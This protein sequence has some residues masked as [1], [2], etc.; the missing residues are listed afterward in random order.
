[1]S[2]SPP[3]SALQEL[4]AGGF[5]AAEPAA[6][7]LPGGNADRRDRAVRTS[8]R[9]NLPDGRTARLI[10]APSLAD[11]AQRH[12]AFAAVCPDLVPPPIFYQTLQNGEAWAES[13]FAGRS[14]ESAASESRDETSAAFAQVVSLL[15][16]TSRPSTES[17][18]R[19]EWQT[20]TGAVESLPIW[21]PGE[22]QLLQDLVWPHLY[23]L[24]AVTPPVT[25][26]TNGDFT[27][28][29][30]LVNERGQP[31]LIDSEFAGDTHFFAEDAVRFH[32]LS[33]SAATWPELYADSLPP[34]GP[35]WQLFFWLRQ[36]MLESANNTAAYLARVRPG[37]LGVIRRLAEHITG[38]QLAGWSVATPTVHF[39]LEAACWEQTPQTELRIAGWCHVPATAPAAIVATQND[40]W[41]GQST[42][43]ERPDVQAHFADA[44]SARA[45]GFSLALPLPVPDAPIVLSARTPD[46]AL[47]PFYSCQAG[48][49]PGRGP[50]VED[51]TRWATLYDPDPATPTGATPG[52]LFSILIPVFNPPPEFL[53]ACL[54][55]VQ[56]Q[57]YARW[58]ICLVDDGSTTAGVAA[59]LREFATEPRLRVQTLPTNGGI[60]RATNAALAAAQGEFIV[61][62]DHDDILRPHAL[63]EFALHLQRESSLDAL[64]SDEDKIT[65]DGVRVASFLKPDFSP[66]YLLGVMYIGH[67]LCV[68]TS[69]ARTAGGFDPAYD[70]LQDFEFFLRLTEH[71]R[72]IG[73][74][75]RQLYHWRQSPGSSALH[76]NVKGD[77][78]RKQAAAVRAHLR[79]RGRSEEVTACGRHRVQLHS[80]GAPTM[81]LVRTAAPESWAAALHHAAGSSRAEVLIV[82]TV[83][84]Q[85]M[86]EP[87][88]RELANLAARP[89]SA[90]VAPLLLAPNGLVWAS[91]WT[92][93]PTGSGPIMRGFDPAGDGYIGSLLC[94]REV[95]AVSLV[96]FA[97]SRE[98][99]LAYPP[100]DDDWLAYS[101]TLRTGGRYHRVCST[102]RVK[103]TSAQAGTAE[104]IR[105]ATSPD[106]FFNPH[107]NAQRADYS[108]ARPLTHTAPVLWHLDTPLAGVLPDGCVTLRG[109]CFAANGKS[110]AALRLRASALT[111]FGVT[112]RPR[113]DVKADL[114]EAPGAN[115]GFEIHGTLPRGRHELVLEAK[116]PEGT[117]VVLLATTVGVNHRFLPRWLGRASW[118]EL[119]SFQFPLQASHP[120]G[121][122]PLEKFPPNP[123][124]GSRLK[125]AIVTP[126]YN[127]AQ[128]LGETMRSVLA[129]TGVTCEYVVQ[130]GGSTD[131]SQALIERMA[132]VD[133]G[134]KTEDSGQWTVD[135][136]QRTEDSISNLQPPIS[137]LRPPAH[138]RCAFA[139]ES[140]P[141]AGQA[142]AIGRAFAKTSGGPEDLMAWIN[143]DD[144]YLPGALAFVADYFAR[145]PEIDVL[146][147]HRILVDESSQE[148]SRWFLPKHDAEVLR[149]YDFVPQETVFWRRRIW[150]R[151]G[152]IDSHFKFA[153]DWD[154]LLRFQ[155]AGAKI[156]RVP[157]FLACFRVHAAQ[158]TS[159]QMHSTG[160]TEIT[161]LRERTFGRAFPPAE[162]E[163]NPHLLRYLRRSA[164]IEFL[165]KMGI[166]TP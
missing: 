124:R 3:V 44:A 30:I 98:L 134:R 121:Q 93:G 21:T 23:P 88:M 108:L 90:L 32:A 54:R 164:F 45:A 129:Q 11:L 106:P 83:E 16:S 12:R 67:A 20:W 100:P 9:V 60:A 65:A 58:E 109:W 118:T 57:H 69:V 86:S 135:R 144:F 113:S 35:A 147:G 50:R 71:T 140:T 19:A 160:Q 34:R 4:V 31:R 17:A 95:A 40:V 154:L 133:G 8:W 68:R 117:W 6:Q 33:P 89:D 166:R 52:P 115:T 143:S 99:L 153:L 87:E 152:G 142:D 46:G 42:L 2:E 145:H 24:L 70:G 74:I 104:Q 91:G 37:R 61:L 150:D 155:A 59:V 123:A 28:D 55:S 138:A 56:L 18:R 76:G 149:L 64:Y 116:L 119:M 27:S 41:L 81:E 75:P 131:G 136:K 96:C 48:D 146:Y 73:H 79:R 103:L 120:P 139:W 156:V 159:A 77:M 85:S 7:P 92:T 84:T 25:R 14:L 38:R 49:L 132:A 78:D 102:V 107:F 53:R 125:L 158:K 97:L 26:W 127:Q 122:H 126:S 101:Q 29:N 94:T 47:L 162:L 51:Y 22:K 105:S 157:Y 151:V 72:R 161:R 80:T 163:R 128:Y 112:G 5:I 66:E 10:L 114:P 15:A 110:I 148:I 1:M 165:W 62:L 39:H 13:F 130:D 111:L 82:V 36:L 43:T 141:D 63:T 137:G